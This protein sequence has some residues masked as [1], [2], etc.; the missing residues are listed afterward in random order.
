MTYS[1]SD[2]FCDWLDVTCHPESTFLSEVS[3]FLAYHFCPVAFVKDGYAGSTTGYRVGS[4]ILTLESSKNFHRASASGSCVREFVKLGVFRDYVNILGSVAHNVTRLD[5]A[6]DLATDAPAFLRGLES[7][8]PDD[9]FSFGRK[10][11][12][13]TRLYSARASD[14][15]LTGTWYVGHRSSAR[16]TAR[17]YDKQAESLEK[18]GEVLPPTTRIEL[19]FKKDYNCSLYDVLMPESL[20]YSH[21]SPSLLDA[22]DKYIAPWS[23]K[24]LVPWVSTPKD[25]TLTLDRF[26]SRVSH[27]PEL[28]KIAELGAQFGD[29][30]KAAVM[31]HF[32]RLLSSALSEA[33]HA[34]S[35]V[36]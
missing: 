17:V 23:P 1:I 7:R 26:D 30:G 33:A 3:Q 34:P 22:P 10:S 11:L 13:V 35:D 14:R 9:V 15:A 19:T 36:T 12:R 16:V 32:E 5:V 20:F 27:S 2:P 4:G 18:R 25:H 29:A 31:R 6:V 21:A 8:Y 28:L 24:G